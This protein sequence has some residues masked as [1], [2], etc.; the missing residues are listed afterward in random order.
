MHPASRIPEADIGQPG[1]W[2]LLTVLLAVMVLLP[3]NLEGC[4]AGHDVTAA[5]HFGGL[6]HDPLM[7]AGPAAG[8]LAQLRHPWQG[9]CNASEVWSLPGTSQRPSSRLASQCHHSHVA[10]SSPC[11]WGTL[12]TWDLCV[13]SVR[14]LCTSKVR[15]P[16]PS[17]LRRHSSGGAPVSS[18]MQS[19]LEVQE[20]Q[21]R[22]PL[23]GCQG[24]SDIGAA[25][26]H[27]HGC[28]LLIGLQAMGFGVQGDLA[29]SKLIPA[30]SS[31]CQLRLISARGPWHLCWQSTGGVALGV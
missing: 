15:H 1:C 6:C 12:G 7:P 27:Q 14:A 18:R 16:E 21:A 5:R 13:G 10:Q 30:G 8:S 4:A 9:C 22:L 11:Q 24:A 2:T 3:H 31:G 19:T 17:H 20:L 28:A 26:G 29:G 25:A 23:Q